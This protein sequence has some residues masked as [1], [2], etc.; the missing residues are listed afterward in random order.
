MWFLQ[1]LLEGPQPHVR[2]G[3]S[4][5][6]VGDKIMIFGGHGARQRFNDLYILDAK[7]KSA[8]EKNCSMF[9]TWMLIK[10]EY[11]LIMEIVGHQPSSWGINFRASDLL[12]YR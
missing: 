4:M 8:V 12:A 10:L 11:Q 7:V 2:E 6:A 3:A 9:W 1:P 5:V